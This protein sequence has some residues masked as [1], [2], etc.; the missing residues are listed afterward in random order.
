MEINK[1][2]DSQCDNNDSRCLCHR[3]LHHIAI[4]ALQAATLIASVATLKQLSKLRYKV[5]LLSK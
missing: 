3:H 1:P 4:V 5:R 2:C